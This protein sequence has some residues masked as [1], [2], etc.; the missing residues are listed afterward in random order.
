MKL[1]GRNP[2]VERLKSNPKTIRMI[3]IQEGQRDAAYI[4]LK[5]KK[6]GIPVANIPHSKMLKMARSINTQGLLVEVDDF[7][8]GD[9]QEILTTAVKKRRTLLFLDNLNDPQNLGSILR[10]CAGLGDFV[11]VLPSHDSVDV[12]EAVLRVACGGDNYIPVA[13]VS[14]LHQAIGDA[15][16]A[17][18]WIAGAVVEEGKDLF[19]ESLPF[20]LAIIIGSEHKGIRDIIRKQLDIQLAIPMAAPRMS[21]NAAQAATIFCYEITKQKNQ[22]RAV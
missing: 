6:W 15:K 4:R 19:Q 3:Y 13:K 12:T 16:K 20:P 21:L 18:F 9:Y 17:G 14:N 10:T 2:V 11:V 22:K 8:Y 7:I 1:Y 5:A